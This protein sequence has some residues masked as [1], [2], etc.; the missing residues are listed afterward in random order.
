MA[1]SSELVA[2]SRIEDRR[3]LQNR[4][5]DGDA[6]ALAARQ[7]HAALADQRLITA[8]QRL[9]ELR[10][11]RQSRGAPH[12]RVRGLGPSEPDVVGDRC[13]GTSTDPAGRSRS[14]AQRRL[15]HALDRL[16]ADQDLAALDVGESQQQPRQRRLAA[17]GSADESDLRAGRDR[18]EKSSN[19]SGCARGSESSRPEARRRSPAART[20]AGASVSTTPADRAAAR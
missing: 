13:D 10:R 19:S 8:R 9:D 14:A 12:L 11:V 6:L 3:V 5:R 17:A 4:A 7:L 16:A 2:S 18:S 20:A 1:E 15:R